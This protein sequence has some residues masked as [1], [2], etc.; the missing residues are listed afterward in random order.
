MAESDT[1]SLVQ[2]I[3][4][5]EIRVDKVEEEQSIEPPPTAPEERVVSL[6]H[7]QKLADDVRELKESEKEL[8]DL[9]HIPK[10]FVCGATKDLNGVIA[11][12]T[13]KYG[14]NVHDTGIVA[15][16]A[17]QPWGRPKYAVDLDSEFVYISRNKMNSWLCYDFLDNRVIPTSYSMKSIDDRRPKSWAFEASNDG[18]S[19]TEIDC[20]EDN[21]DLNDPMAIHN[22]T[23]SNIP[24]KDGFRFI[25][26]RQTGANHAGD[27]T[28]V[29]SSLEIFGTFCWAN[30]RESEF[31]YDGYNILD[32]IIAHLTREYGGNVHEQGILK[33]TG[34]YLFHP[35][36]V[37]NLSTR[38][39]FLSDPVIDSWICYDFQCRQIIPA[40]YSVMSRTWP[41]EDPCNHLKSWVFEGSNDGTSWTE[42]DRRENNHDLNSSCAI[43]NF[44]ISRPSGCVRFI[45]I[46]QIG[47]NH[48]GGD[49]LSFAALEI[50]GLL[51]GD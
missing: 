48:K 25:R 47:P 39:R 31:A 29:I 13:Q 21:Y 32:G 18:S 10:Y 7:F 17:C 9:D 16:T 22:F 42:L 11:Y 49:T 20:R 3:H 45:R 33:V 27:H 12:L 46:R 8:R 36:C 35:K 30:G 37:A 6:E 44:E 50:F 43:Q 26:I 2:R 24:G 40:S 14:G 41:S 4:S 28:L 19:W 15:V 1:Q 34:N 23:T 38:E 5:L 51:L